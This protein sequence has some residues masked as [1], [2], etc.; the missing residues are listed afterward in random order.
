MQRKLNR[1][2]SPDEI[3]GWTKK[4]YPDDQAMRLCPETI[5]RALLLREDHG[6]HQR[7]ATKLRTGRRVRKT[8][9]RTRTGQ[10]SRIR[11]MTMIDQ[12]PAEVETRLEAGHWGG[13]LIVGLGS[14]SAMMTLQSTGKTT[15]KTRICC[16]DRQKPPYLSGTVL[17]AGYTRITNPSIYTGLFIAG[18]AARSCRSGGPSNGRVE[19]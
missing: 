2:W 12:R 7:Y 18:G 1:F 8:R 16:V 9:W 11:N 15:R 13:D 5:Y 19:P 10:G 17:R 4:T 6:L 14:V 3:C